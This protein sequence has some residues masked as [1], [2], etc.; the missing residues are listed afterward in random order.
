MNLS[1]VVPVHNEAENL[2]PLLEEICKTLDGFLDFEVIYVD[3]GSTDDSYVRLIDLARHI[4]QLRVLKHRRG[5][6]Q[7]T[8]LLTGIRHAKGGVIATLDGDGQN[9]PADIRALLNALETLQKEHALAM[10]VGYRKKRQDTEWRRISSRIANAVRA[11]LLG[12]N[13]PDTGCGLKVFS[14]ELFLLLP[15]FDHMHRF[16]PALAQRAG[17]RVVSVEVNHRARLAGV[18]KY[19]TW[20]RLW[21]GIVDILGVMWLQSRAHIPI[22]E[23]V[24]QKQ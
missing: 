16:L 1:V 22:V 10:V 12:D 5:Y 9:D 2:K 7:S 4:P 21:V 18:S 17:G 8:A 3:D 20:N 23:E 11:K 15:Y 14:K 24:V 19:G 6:G 13:T